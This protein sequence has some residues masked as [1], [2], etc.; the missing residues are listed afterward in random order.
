[1]SQI[2]KHNVLLHMLQELDDIIEG[3]NS[4]NM[5]KFL[6]LTPLTA[7]IVFPKV[8]HSEISYSFMGDVVWVVDPLN[9]EQTKA[10]HFFLQYLEQ[11]CE[12][13]ET[14]REYLY[15]IYQF[16]V[17]HPFKPFRSRKTVYNKL[18]TGKSSFSSYEFIVYNLCLHIFTTILLF[19]SVNPP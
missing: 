9:H 18:I 2:L 15:I 4:V 11:R 17:K 6:K 5:Q 8:E 19:F 12:S 3:F 16:N 1:M 14:E 10:Y 7:D 13:T